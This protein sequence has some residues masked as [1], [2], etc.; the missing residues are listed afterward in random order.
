MV[1][2]FFNLDTVHQFTTVLMISG[3]IAFTAF[4]VG[5]FVKYTK[6]SKMGKNG[7]E[8]DSANSDRRKHTVEQT[9]IMYHKLFKF[10][11][12]CETPEGLSLGVTDK[13][14][15]LSNYLSIQFS[16]M[17]DGF[18]EFFRTSEK[19]EYDGLSKL[20]EL[21]NEMVQEYTKKSEKM[22]SMTS[23]GE[24]CGMPKCAATKFAR[25]HRRHAKQLFDDLENALSDRIYISKR[26][27]AFTMANA[28]YFMLR[29]TI[30]DAANTLPDLN[31]D[32][33]KE[34]DEMLREACT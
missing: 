21:Y 10:F 27:R 16:V 13:A 11:E 3:L 31:G 6:P 20:P 26:E 15:V 29:E 22:I 12:S 4:V 25:W 23:K 9:S 34:L 8:F 32:F 24:L 2:A 18:C 1:T 14:I 17:Y 5:A 28:I 19:N 30:H 33:D 7:L